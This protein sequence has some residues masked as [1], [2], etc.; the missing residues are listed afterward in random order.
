MRKDEQAVQDLQ[1]CMKDFDAESF[2]ISSP[3]LRSLQSGLVA[4]PELVHDLES[5]LPHGQAQAGTLMQ[6][7]VFTKIK[8]LTAIIHRNKKL[9]FASERICAPSGAL[10]KVAQMERSGLAALVDLAEG[11]V[12]IQLESA[13]EGRVTEECLSLYNPC[14]HGAD[15]AA[16]HPHTPEDREA[17]K[18]DGSEYLW[19]D[20]VEKICAIIFSRHANASHIIL[21]NDKYDL[22]FSIKNDEHDCR[23]AKHPH[24]QNVFPKPEDKFPGAAEFNELMVNSGNKV[25]LQKL[26]KEQLKT[27][28]CRAQGEIIYCEGERSTNLGTGVASRDYVFKHPEADTILLSAYAKLRSRNYTGTVVLDCEDTDVFVQVAYVSQ[29]LPDDLLIRRKHAFINCQAMLSEE[30]AKI[31]IPLHVITG[32]DHT[33]GFYGHGKKKVMEKAWRRQECC[34]PSEGQDRREHNGEGVAA[35]TGES[36]RGVP[37]SQGPVHHTPRDHSCTRRDRLCH[38]A[39]IPAPPAQKQLPAARLLRHAFLLAEANNVQDYRSQILSTFGTVMKM[40]STKKV[41]K[42]LSGQGRGSAEW[43]TSIGNEYSQIV[44]FVL[45]CEESAQKLQPVCRGV[46]ERFRRAN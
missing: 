34:A 26:L 3:K 31:I 4:S 1:A 35:G 39:D 8:P 20:Y 25:R 16:S 21:V 30:V 40:D 43:F 29:Q 9:N 32:S 45:T 14:G 18:R 11:S 19:S 41:V 36:R 22:P 6:E 15:L 17:R 5:A 23:A 28:V 46:M 44:S 27:R 42:K 13:L 33:S 12:L 7:R 24:I 2:D 37:P 38:E 10:M